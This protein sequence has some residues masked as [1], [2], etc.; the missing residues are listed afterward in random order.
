MNV[1][2]RDAQLRALVARV[3]R[4][5]SE[6]YSDELFVNDIANLFALAEAN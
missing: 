6:V 4:L 3:R 5:P 2:E 1:A